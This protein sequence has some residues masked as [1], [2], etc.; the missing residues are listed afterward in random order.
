MIQKIL[1]KKV[2]KELAKLGETEGKSLET[3]YINQEN[4][5]FQ[6]TDKSQITRPIGDNLEDLKLKLQKYLGADFVSLI[7][8]ID[9]HSKENQKINFAI[10]YRDKDGEVNTHRSTF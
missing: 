6:Y 8:L 7:V 4:A 10:K 5:L 1:F 9:D 3:I 2:H